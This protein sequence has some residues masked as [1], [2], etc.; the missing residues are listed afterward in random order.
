MPVWFTAVE[1]H[2]PF[3]GP[4]PAA[5]ADAYLAEDMGGSSTFGG[6]GG[7]NS[8]RS[9]YGGSIFG[10]KPGHGRDP[11]KGSMV[12]SKAAGGGSSSTALHRRMDSNASAKSGL[13]VGRAGGASAG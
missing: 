8:P 2:G 6:G 7:G 13:G 11:S 9:V 1:N 3:P 5:N 10:S 4:P 12:L